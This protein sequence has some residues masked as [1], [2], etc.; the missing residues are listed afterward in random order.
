MN[1]VKERS[2][3]RYTK[4]RI[5]AYTYIECTMR[6]ETDGRNEMKKK[7]NDPNIQENAHN[8]EKIHNPKDAQTGEQKKAPG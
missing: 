4:E 6:E 1:A 7:K 2:D 3:S 5:H 8:K